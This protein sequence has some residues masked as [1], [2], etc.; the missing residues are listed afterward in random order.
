MQS[1]FHESLAR[2][3][4][5]RSGSDRAFGL[6]MA[7]ACSVIAGIGFWV[8]TSHWPYWTAAAIAFAVAAWQWPA[9]L[10]PLNQLWFRFGLA[11]HWVINPLVMGLLFFA[12]VTPVGLLMRLC[13]KRPLG[14]DF[15]R[16]ATSYWL[17]RDK[18]ELQPGPMT[19]QY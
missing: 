7:A 10:G 16:E 6:V 18:T 3:A 1:N 12:V 8:G 17:M 19:K 9:V 11:L 5:I 13:R 4:D 2:D 15:D 14:L